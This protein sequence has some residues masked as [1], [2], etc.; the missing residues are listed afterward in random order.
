MSVSYSFKALIVLFFVLVWAPGFKAPYQFDDYT[1]PLQDPASE[2]LSAWGNTFLK[3]LRPLTKLTYAFE[4][5][6]GFKAAPERRVFNYLLAISTLILLSLI[7]QKHGAGLISSHL[8]AILWATHPVHAETFIA[9]SGRPTLLA[10]FFVLLSLL[11]T[12]RYRSIVFAVLATLS[13]EVAI[14]FLLYQLVRF[15]FRKDFKVL[16]LVLLMVIIGLFRERLWVLFKFSWLEVPH[17]IHWWDNLAAISA[18]L[19]FILNPKAVGIDPDFPLFVSALWFFIG[20]ILISIILFLIIRSYRQKS[21]LG[22]LLILWAALILPTQSLILKLDP[23]ALRPL[24]YS[25]LVFP[26]LIA[27]FIKN[28]K[29]PTKRLAGLLSLVFLV[30]SSFSAYSLSRN[31]ESPVSLWRDA[32]LKSPEKQRPVL[33][34]SY[35]LVRENKLLEAE[36]VLLAAQKKWPTSIEVNQKVEAVK[37]LLETET[38][39]KDK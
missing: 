19:Y 14:L 17:F 30:I 25:S 34:L 21:E 8:L 22:A 39:L 1:T 27:S 20:L 3:T 38:L 15:D 28:W 24:S 5:S 36:K 16:G 33:N 29:P 32:S 37:T 11:T 35:F 26:L 2:S 10:I 7:L 23:L 31:Y 6:I 18:G 9:I 13:K 4:S 12:N